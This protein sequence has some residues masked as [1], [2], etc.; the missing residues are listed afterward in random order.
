MTGK[1]ARVGN[2]ELTTVI[3]T[4]CGNMTVLP[5]LV[6]YKGAKR[7]MGWFQHFAEES[8]VGEYVFA[9]SPK[10]WIIHKLG[11]ECLKHFDEIT[12]PRVTASS[13]YRLHGLD[14]HWSLS[15]IS[16]PIAYHHIVPTCFNRG[17]GF[18]FSTAESVWKM[19]NKIFVF[20]E[21]E[22]A[23]SSCGSIY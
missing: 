4:I 8:Q 15:N 23:F 14:A 6:V 1:L 10:G 9:M 20:H 17:Y 22:G 2:R 11:M 18:I 12:K 21:L 3:E 16:S 13:P 5:P 7:Y 19:Y